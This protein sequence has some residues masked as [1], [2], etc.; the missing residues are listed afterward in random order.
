M[1]IELCSFCGNRLKLPWEFVFKSGAHIFPFGFDIVVPIR[2]KKG[3]V[4][5]QKARHNVQACPQCLI[6]IYNGNVEG[7]FYALE[8]TE[9]R[10]ARISDNDLLK[11]R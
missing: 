6:S 3:N 2:D 10:M 4:V 11:G 7:M 1:Y 8:Q 9:Q 5:G